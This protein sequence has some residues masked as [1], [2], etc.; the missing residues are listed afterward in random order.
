[1]DGAATNGRW[2]TGWLL[3]AV[4]HVEV[5]GSPR[6]ARGVCLDHPFAERIQ[7]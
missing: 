1:V 2:S 4:V 6:V 7:L 3:D 5:G